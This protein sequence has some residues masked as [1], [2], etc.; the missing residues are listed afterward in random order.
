MI[1][2]EDLARLLPT[3]R[4]YYG[5][6]GRYGEE[7]RWYPTVLPRLFSEPDYYNLPAK[8][9]RLRP[10]ERAVD[11]LCGNPVPGALTI[12][13]ARSRPAA[14]VIALDPS[15]QLLDACKANLASVGLRN[16]E[17]VLSDDEALDLPPHSV[18]VIVNRLGFHHI[19]DGAA[20]M[21]EYREALR[22]GGR[23]VL[24]DFTVPDGDD[25][26]EHYINSIYRSRDTTHVKIRSVK[27]I[28]A[29]L[30]AAGFKPIE[31]LPWQVVH[32]TDEFGFPDGSAKR[33]Y[34][35]AFLS[36]SPNARAVHKV[37]VRGEELTFT[38][39]AFV[40]GAQAA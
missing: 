9:A 5:P 1:T 10:G 26:S 2:R 33:R 20:T 12:A 32:L 37:A 6:G 4:A 18:D 16:A 30:E 11:V 17:W 34:I 8:L 29:A 14:T 31:T 7:G 40:L 22:P 13:L 15:Q 39:P 28:V 38:H 19:T 21:K 25:D 3:C 23:V 35:D 27:E 36:G 24:L